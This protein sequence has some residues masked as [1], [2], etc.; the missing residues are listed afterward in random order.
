[1][2]GRKMSND[3]SLSRSQKCCFTMFHYALICFILFVYSYLCHAE[4]SNCPLCV[5]VCVRACVSVRNSGD[6]KDKF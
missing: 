2:V 3:C 5:C 1:M 6:Q 4:L